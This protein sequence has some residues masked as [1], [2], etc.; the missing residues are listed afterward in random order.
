[1]T[2]AALSNAATSKYSSNSNSSKYYYSNSKIYGI[3]SI[4][5]SNYRRNYNSI[6][7]NSKK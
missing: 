5:C 4:N 6:N 3:S 7:S 2:A 1:M